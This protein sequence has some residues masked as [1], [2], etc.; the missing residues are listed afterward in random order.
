MNGK[1]LQEFLRRVH[2]RVD[3]DFLCRFYGEHDQR[4]L[5][6]KWEAL[7]ESFFHWFCNLPTLDAN[8][9]YNMINS[10]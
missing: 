5:D 1:E 6:E 7:R 8:R 2:C 3:Y 9:F 4:Y 10:D